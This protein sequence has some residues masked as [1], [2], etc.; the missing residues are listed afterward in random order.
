MSKIY[1]LGCPDPIADSPSGIDTKVY[2]R[3]NDNSLI[4]IQEIQAI[5][6]KENNGYAFIELITALFTDDT[7][8]HLLKCN[9]IKDFVVESRTEHGSIL[10][11]EFLN[12]T[13]LERRWG[14]SVDDLIT[15]ITT[16]FI[17]MSCI[18]WTKQ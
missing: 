15:E 4:Q 3:L 12:V 18:P 16:K 6:V 14:I 2:A 9:G 8:A 1:A 11:A 10:K 7:I 5:S 17:C 13:F